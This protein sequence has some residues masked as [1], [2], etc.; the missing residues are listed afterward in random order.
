MLFGR[1]VAYAK[2][3]P[4]HTIVFSDASITVWSA[5]VVRCDVLISK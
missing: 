3:C 1:R 2:V 5:V 4:E